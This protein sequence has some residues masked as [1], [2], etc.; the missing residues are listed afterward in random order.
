[1][2]QSTAS[3]FEILNPFAS[4]RNK[5][6]RDGMYEYIPSHV[7]TRV[8]QTVKRHFRT[9]NGRAARTFLDLGCGKG[10]AMYTA[11]DAG[12]IPTGV[13]I[14]D[15]LLRLARK[16]QTITFIKDAKKLTFIKGD[17]LKWKPDKQYDIVY[18]YHPLSDPKLHTQFIQHVY[19][20]FPIGQLFVCI[21]G[22]DGHNGFKYISECTCVSIENPVEDKV[23]YIN[24]N[25]VVAR[26]DGYYIVN[27]NGKFYRVKATSLR[28]SMCGGTTYTTSRKT[29][30]NFELY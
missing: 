12:L 22:V 3:L 14:S 4:Y 13:E 18:F 17:I 19:K 28:R 2:R 16:I 1:M 30:I 10:G 24:G 8:L 26:L 15:E 11:L 9:I 25:P 7:T 27:M 21:G 6:R 29:Q 23:R 20:S 5:D